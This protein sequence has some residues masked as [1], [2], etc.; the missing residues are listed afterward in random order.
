M[1]DAMVYRMLPVLS[2]SAGFFVHSVLPRGAFGAYDI[3]FRAIITGAV[4]GVTAL[5]FMVLSKRWSWSSQDLSAP[6]SFA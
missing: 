4:A 5:L 6:S 1:L 2:I 3:A